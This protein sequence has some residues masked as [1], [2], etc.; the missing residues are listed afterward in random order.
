M[1]LAL[2]L[3]FVSITQFSDFWVM[4]YGNWKH[5]LD[6]FKLWKTELCGIFVNLL[7]RMGPTYALSHQSNFMSMCSPP[8]SLSSIF[9]SSSNTQLSSPLFIEPPQTHNSPLH[10]H[11]MP[12]PQTHNSPPPQASQHHRTSHSQVL[13][14]LKPPWF[15]AL[16]LILPWALLS[17]VRL[18]SL[19]RTTMV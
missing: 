3:V 19:N 7:N 8:Y 16:K 17:H 10:E 11:H 12:P 18:S 2:F 4:S 14:C 15:P 1:C 9:F 13:H 5:I 6:V